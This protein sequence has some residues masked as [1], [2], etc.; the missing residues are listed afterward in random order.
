M[1]IRSANSSPTESRLS[2]TTETSK[3]YFGSLANLRSQ[4]ITTA[5]A[6]GLVTTQKVDGDGNGIFEQVIVSTRAPDGSS[7][8][9]MQYFADAGV[10]AADL[11]RSQGD[12][13]R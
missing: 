8:E 12:K 7:S 3:S 13:P 2:S 11:Y 10:N 4:T 6:N 1:P 9:V 5:S